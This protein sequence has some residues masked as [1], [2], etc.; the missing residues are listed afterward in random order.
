MNRARL[1]DVLLRA[2]RTVFLFKKQ[3]GSDGLY[4][5]THNNRKKVV[6]PLM[7]KLEFDM[8][9]TVTKRRCFPCKWFMSQVH[10]KANHVNVDDNYHIYIYISYIHYQRKS[11]AQLHPLVHTYPQNA[12]TSTYANVFLIMYIID[13][14]LY[15]Y[16]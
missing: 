6:I 1:V 9:S 7:E 10:I 13:M 12:Y 3:I 11:T 5:H 14:Y 2:R 4:T 16:K 8:C 15:I